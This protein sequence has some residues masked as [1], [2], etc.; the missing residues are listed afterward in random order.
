MQQYTTDITY[1]GNIVRGIQP[2][3]N[4]KQ[5]SQSSKASVQFPPKNAMVLV[6]NRLLSSPLSP[7][8]FLPVPAILALLVLAILVAAPAV[9]EIAKVVAVE[10]RFLEPLVD[11]VVYVARPPGRGLPTAR[12]RRKLL[13]ERTEMRRA[14]AARVEAREEYDKSLE[15]LALVGRRLLGES[16]HGRVEK[17]PGRATKLGSV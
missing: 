2:T 14:F 12:L 10:F 3:P 7:L 8:E 6:L 9:V 5:K 11:L 15:R 17:L 4:S 1:S 13:Q 16:G